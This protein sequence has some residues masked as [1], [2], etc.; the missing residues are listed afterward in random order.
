MIDEQ[1]AAQWAKDAGVSLM[2]HY[3]KDDSVAHMAAI[4]L[5]LLQDREEREKYLER[6]RNQ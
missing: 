5:A 4:V 3:G 6:S 1:R 2:R